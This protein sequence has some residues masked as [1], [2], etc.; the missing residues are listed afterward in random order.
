MREFKPGEPRG[1][2]TV[3]M[4]LMLPLLILLVLGATDLGRLFY[5]AITVANAAR[6]GLSYAVLDES[7]SRDT[8]KITEIAENDIGSVGGVTLNVS[9][10]CECADA[11][12]VDCETGTCDEGASRVYV[13]LEAQK[14]FTTTLPYPGV[15]HSVPITRA[16]YMRAR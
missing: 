6:A 11:S 5:D 10:I 3:E 16:A 15:P 12:V 9:R 14:T 7:K 8:G 1:T 4:A 2:S 13:R